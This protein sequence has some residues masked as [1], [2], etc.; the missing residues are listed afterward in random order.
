MVIGVVT[1]ATIVFVCQ[2]NF[3]QF[4]N[5]PLATTLVKNGAPEPHKKSND[6]KTFDINARPNPFIVNDPHYEDAKLEETDEY[7]APG[8]RKIQRQEKYKERKRN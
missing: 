8:A 7:G 4:Q 5:A 3:E 1:L 6:N 2:E